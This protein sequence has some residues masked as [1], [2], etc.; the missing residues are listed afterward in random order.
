MDTWILIFYLT[1]GQPLA[2]AVI[3]GF[4]TEADCQRTAEHL[5]ST[6]YRLAPGVITLCVPARIATK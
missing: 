2:P 5:H 3:T 1:F 6:D 4:V